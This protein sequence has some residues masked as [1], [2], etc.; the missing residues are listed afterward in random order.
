MVHARAAVAAREEF[1]LF[2]AEVATD[3]GRVGTPQTIVETTCCAR[4]SVRSVE[5][6]SA[7][8]DKALQA[9]VRPAEGH[10][11]RRNP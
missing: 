11:E 3:I 2:H 6:R 10:H 4:E 1:T 7:T 5:P 9:G 8:V